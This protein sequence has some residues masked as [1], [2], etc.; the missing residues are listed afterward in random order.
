MPYLESLIREGE[1]Q[2]Q[3]FKFQITDSRKIAR[4]LSAFAN[5]DGGRLLI[6]VKDNGKIVGINPD[7]EYHM[8]A[9]ATDLYCE[10]PVE[11]HPQVH[12]SDERSV[13]EITVPPSAERPHFVKEADGSKKAY[14]R[15]NDEN[16]VAN[17][18]FLKLWRLNDAPEKPTDTWRGENENK[19]LDLLKNDGP[20]SVSQIS[21]QCQMPRFVVEKILA[22]ML[23][24]NI[25][26]WEMREGTLRFCL[27]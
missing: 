24:W 7:E 26:G 21:K 19:I 10:P 8:V 3:D 17:K 14:F 1:H 16:F 9:G 25:I 11:F 6:G 13:L 5:T 27:V 15:Y 22:L 18:V 20:S 2:T 4:T 23:R 12:L